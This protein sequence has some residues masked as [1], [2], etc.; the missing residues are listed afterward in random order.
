MKREARILPEIVVVGSLNLDLVARV[1][2]RPLPGETVLGSALEQHPGGKGANQA[3]AAARL[4][5]RV[6]MVGAVGAD[7]FGDALLAS[8]RRDGVETRWVERRAG[9]GTGVALITVDDQA[10]NSI[11]VIPGANGLVDPE[12]VARATPAIRAAR[13]MLLQLEIPLPAVMAA[14]RLGREHG[15]TVLLD[16]APAPPPDRPLPPELLALADYVTPNESEAAALTGLPVNPDD[17]RPVAEALLRRGARRALIKLG[18]RGAY[19]LG[20]EGEFRHPGFRV[21]AVDTTAAGDAFAGGLAAALHRGMP[22]GEALTWGCA[23]GALAAT[24]PGAQEAMPMR[25]EFEGFLRE[26]SA[27]P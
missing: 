4:G 20:P 9:S 2:R 1:P 23:A 3:V 12:Q 5:A 16:P 10:E 6:A 25:D 13:V 7:G 21:D 17:P 11:I 22:A 8:L 14:A 27:S 15:L 24:R 26:R 18:A 19:L